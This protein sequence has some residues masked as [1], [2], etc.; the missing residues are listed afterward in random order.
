MS[1]SRNASNGG[2]DASKGVGR[3][4]QDKGTAS[5]GRRSVCLHIIFAGGT[6]QRQEN[7][8]AQ[9]ADSTLFQA[10]AKHEG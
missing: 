9:M 5:Q 10:Q 8:G 3:G 4:R 1:K 2:P 7:F 6:L